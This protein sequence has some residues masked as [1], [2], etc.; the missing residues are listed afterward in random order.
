MYRLGGGGIRLFGKKPF[1]L[2]DQMMK[3]IARSLDMLHISALNR[4]R[5]VDDRPAS[6]QLRI[7]ARNYRRRDPQ[8][9]S[10]R[11]YANDFGIERS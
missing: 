3:V 10:P 4:A 2:R 6:L 9:R 11:L 8:L 1:L 7:V 5:H